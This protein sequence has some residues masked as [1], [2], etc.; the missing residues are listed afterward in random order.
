MVLWLGRLVPALGRNLVQNVDGSLWYCREPSA[1]DQSLVLRS[2]D[3]A[4]RVFFAALCNEF[5]KQCK[6][7]I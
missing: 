5:A 1:F 3:M 7:M 6:V 4:G 2:I